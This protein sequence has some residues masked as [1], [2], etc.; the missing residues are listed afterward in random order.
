MPTSFEQDILPLFTANDINHMKLGKVYLDSYQWMSDP[1]P[2]S[3]GS[4]QP[5]PDHGNARSVYGYLTGD[6]K[7]RM[8]IG[9]PFW[10]AA[11]LALFKQWMEDGFSP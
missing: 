4:C 8:P 6:C 5:F 10:D 7:P 3:V 9:A 11:R 2:G 1:A